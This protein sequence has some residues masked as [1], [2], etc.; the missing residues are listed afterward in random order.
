MTIPRRLAAEAVMG[1]RLAGG[2]AAIALLAGVPWQCDEPA[3]SQTFR[4]GLFGLDKLHNIDCP[5]QY[6]DHA[7][8]R[9]L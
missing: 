8:R 7:L 3:D 1:E 4:R 5:V 6:L 2:N 9:V